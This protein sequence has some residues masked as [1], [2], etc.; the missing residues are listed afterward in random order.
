M[1]LTTNKLAAATAVAAALSMLAAPLAA[2]D[3]PRPAAVEAYDGNAGNVRNHRDRDDW[4]DYDD[5]WD[6]D[7]DIDTGDVIAG[8]LVRVW[9]RLQPDGTWLA[10]RIARLDRG[11]GCLQYSSA[12]RAVHGNQV[13]LFDGRALELGRGI[14]VRGEVQP[15]AVIVVSGCVPA[16]TPVPEPAQPAA[17]APVGAAIVI[18]QNNQAITLACNGSS[19][20]VRGNK[21]TVTLLGACGS[22]TILGNKNTI[23]LGSAVSIVNRGNNNIIIQQR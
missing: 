17:P 20:T 22:V 5:D 16:R 6:D 4:D 19:V 7:D 3:F 13:E 18:R 9:G 10:R 1:A 15:A 21:N 14:A 2:A 23:T 8:V 12:V 11:R